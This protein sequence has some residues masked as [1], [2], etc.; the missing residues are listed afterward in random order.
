MVC[1]QPAINTVHLNSL[2]QT[3]SISKRKIVVSAYNN[4]LGVPAVFDKFY[5]SALSSVEDDK[6][7]R[8]IIRSSLEDLEKVNFPGGGVDI[9]TMEDYDKLR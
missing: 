2:I 4:T 7:A 9:D 6:G 3:F 1:D 8:S 5:F